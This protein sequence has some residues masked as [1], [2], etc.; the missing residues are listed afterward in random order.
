MGL[1]RPPAFMDPSLDEDMIMDSGVNFASGGGGI[2]NETATY[3]VSSWKKVKPSDQCY[4]VP[5]KKLEK[6]IAASCRSKGSHST[7]R[8]SCSWGRRS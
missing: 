6:L 1:L 7:G 3:F 2:L 8:S 5:P 4:L